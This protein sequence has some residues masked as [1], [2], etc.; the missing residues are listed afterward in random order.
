V[1]YAPPTSTTHYYKRNERPDTVLTEKGEQIG[2]I[3]AFLKI[4]G[5]GQLAEAPKTD[6]GVEMCLAYQTRGGCYK[7][8]GRHA[9]HVH[10]NAA[11]VARLGEFVEKGL[12]KKATTAPV[13]P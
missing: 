3:N 6:S 13:V 1:P 2:K 12:A 10:L 4:V 9:G 5:D 8:C 7:D 11:E